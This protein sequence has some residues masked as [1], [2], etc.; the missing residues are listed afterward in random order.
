MSVKRK[1]N[2]RNSVKSK[3]HVCKCPMCKTLHK[4]SIAYRGT[5]RPWI[6]CNICKP[7]VASRASSIP[8]TVQSHT[9]ISYASHYE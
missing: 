3:M 1:D 4:Q 5:T 7:K 2:S 6:Y 9:T 8:D